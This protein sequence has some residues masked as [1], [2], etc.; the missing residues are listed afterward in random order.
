MN[1]FKIRSEIQEAFNDQT[2]SLKEKKYILKMSILL[3]KTMKFLSSSL[4]I[5]LYSMIPTL[6][7]VFYVFTKKEIGDASYISIFLFSAQF[8]IYEFIFKKWLFKDS[9]KNRQDFLK[10]IDILKDIKKNLSK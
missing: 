8:I 6:F 4:F 2:V 3:Y 1:S 7:F 9:D 10:R 5:F